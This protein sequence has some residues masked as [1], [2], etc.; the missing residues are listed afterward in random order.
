L[1][2]KISACFLVVVRGGILNNFKNVNCRRL[3]SR[4][5]AEFPFHGGIHNKLK[6]SRIMTNVLSPITIGGDLKL[7]NRVALAP[8][9]RARTGFDGVPKPWNVEYYTQRASSG[10]IISEATHISEQAN[11]WAWAPKIY[12]S[13]VWRV[14]FRIV[15]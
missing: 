1:K 6:Q 9:T 7:K 8:L 3:E 14:L 10:L 13:E 11:G 5:S 4:S 12:T 15:E 2:T